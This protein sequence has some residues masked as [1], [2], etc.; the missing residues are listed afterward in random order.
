MYHHFRTTLTS[1]MIVAFVV[2]I[3]LW[4]QPVQAAVN[5]SNPALVCKSG[6][7]SSDE[8]W[9]ADKVYVVYSNVTVPAG[10][11]LTIESGTVVKFNLYAG[12]TI[13]GTLI[14][15]GV[16]GNPVYFTSIR[17]DTIDGDTDNE[18]NVPQPGNWQSLHFQTSSTGMLQHTEFRYGGNISTAMVQVDVNANVTIRASVFKSGAQCAISMKP[19]NDV[20]LEDMSFV[21]FTGNVYNGLC[22]DSGDI[23]AHTTWDETEAVYILTG[24]VRVAFGTTLTLG[25]GVVIKFADVFL[26]ANLL[27]NGTLLAQG[28]TDQP[29]Y[30]TSIYDSTIGGASGNTTTTPSP[31]NWGWVLFRTGSSGVLDHVEMRY[32]GKNAKDAILRQEVG[33]D[34]S[35]NAG[36]FVNGRSCPLSM[37]PQSDFTLSNMSP[38]SF[39]GNEFNGI[40]V[41][42][43]G[44]SAHTT[45]DE[46]EAPYVPQSDITVAF[47]ATLTWGPGIVVK[48][49]DFNTDFF[50]DGILNVNGVAGQPVTLTSI[51]DDTIGGATDNTTNPPAR[52]D[53]GRILFRS[54]GT[55]E[56]NQLELR[57][58]GQGWVALGMLEQDVGAS[59]T[60]N[61]GAFKYSSSCALATHPQNDFTMINLASTSVIGNET[62][63]VCVRSGDISA[64]TIWDETEIP[65]VPQGD[66]TVAFGATLTWGP[67]IVVKPS[68]SETDFF[69]DGI[70]NVN[71]VAGQPVTLTSIRDDTI[72]GATD[73]TTNPP[74]RGDWGRIL[75]RGTG[76]ATF[77]MVELRYGGRFWFNLPMVEQALDAQVTINASTFRYGSGCA[78]AI[79]PQTDVTLTN[80][81]VANF[82]GNGTNGICVQGGGISANTTWDETE[83]PYVPQGDITVTAG[84][85]LTWGPGVVIKPKDFS[86]EFLIDGIL[87]ANGT[88]SQ[89]IY[90]TSIYDSTVGGV[91]ISSTTP[92]AP[93]QWGRILFRS[94]SSGTLSH[95]VLRYGGDSFFGSY[96]AIHVD[97]ASPVLRY[98]MLANNR[99]GLRSSGTAANPVVEYCNIVG[100][101]TAGIQNDTPNHWI[102]ALNNWWGNV[103]GPND[104]SNADGFVNNGSGD[105]VSN[106]VK[107][108]PW[109]QGPVII[110]AGQYRM[111]VPHIVR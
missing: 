83:A 110:S 75:V 92:P 18:V 66:I 62:N 6:T 103:N 8:V 15:N 107:Y 5:C 28:T 14:T 68:D 67:G 19:Q 10:V 16:S 89:P 34:V 32:G 101:T 29:I 105:K 73:N 38:A 35:I 1:F 63:G 109:L 47:G 79:H 42:S 43:G 97:N 78:V 85:T 82:S 17:D 70:L 77:N 64:N 39:A 40:C 44:V 26:G 2:A 25:A 86:V 31:G 4:P 61:G 99:Y 57:Y 45:W 84:V 80:M 106:F 11:T 58:G 87:S 37:P 69:I 56:L 60:I 51:R 91:T 50:I 24:D 95:I 41:D 22:V 88:Q 59:V 30:F 111:Y 9:T 23:S 90:V 52:G 49:R 27:V 20:T 98:C 46:T 74:A 100:N 96:G 12:L 108:Q 81:T 7:L 13:Q 54:T 104:A 93:G 53:W 48:P 94:G 3:I 72:G 102:S 55:G 36:R 21:N 65:Y 33:A 76:S 71:G